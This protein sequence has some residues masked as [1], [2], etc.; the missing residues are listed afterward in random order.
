MVFA[1]TS[2]IVA[3]VAGTVMSTQNPGRSDW[4]RE[5]GSTAEDEDAGHAAV[6]A[7]RA[8]P[9]D[10]ADYIEGMCRSLEA[11]AAQSGNTV[12][13][14]LLALAAEEASRSAVAGRKAR[15]G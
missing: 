11:V 7:E 8:D 3:A 15:A 12:V 4:E 2:S 5:L 13:Q 9:T 1:K 10:V 6:R 14:R